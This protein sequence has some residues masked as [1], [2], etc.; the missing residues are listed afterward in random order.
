MLLVCVKSYITADINDTISHLHFI[1]CSFVSTHLFV[2][3][4]EYNKNVAKKYGNADI[5]QCWAL[6]HLVATSIANNDFLD[7]DLACQQ[8]PFPKIL[9]EAQ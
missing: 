6:A 1:F 7:D 8:I 9:L 4:C 2:E 3:M 5:V